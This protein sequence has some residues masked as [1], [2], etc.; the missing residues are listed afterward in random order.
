MSDKKYMNVNQKLWDEKTKVHVNS[1]F[2]NI[3]K[4]KK[5]ATT[6]KDIELSELGDVKNKSLLHLQCHFGLDT[7]SW[8]RL[9]AKVTGV[10]FSEEAICYAKRLSQDINIPAKFICSNIYDLPG[11]MSDEYD[12]VFTSYGVLC[13]LPDLKKWANVISNFLK[14]GGI[15]YI[16]EGHPI[17][18]IFDNERETKKLKAKYSYFHSKDPMRWEAEGTYADRNAVITN[19]SF[20]WT[21]C[22]SDII[23]S[24]ITAG[25]TIEFIHEFPYSS[26]DHYSFMDKNDN[27]WWYLENVEAKIPLTFSLCAKKV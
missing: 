10:D 1:E 20:E 16:V 17:N 15:F 26:Y 4:F 18:N 5:G 21:H 9:G 27:G 25:L 24:L 7:L 11:V 8:A 14:K 19:P 6:L 22:M 13:W 2:Y 3:D 12:I 23:N